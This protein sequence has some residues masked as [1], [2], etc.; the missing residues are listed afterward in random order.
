[1]FPAFREIWNWCND[2]VGKWYEVA[3]TFAMVDYVRGMTEKL[4]YKNSDSGLSQQLIF[5]FKCYTGRM[6]GDQLAGC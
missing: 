1:M 6:E 2:F 3:Q 5:E 4:S